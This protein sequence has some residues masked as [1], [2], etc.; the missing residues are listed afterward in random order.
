MWVGWLCRGCNALCA[1]RL[2]EGWEKAQKVVSDSSGFLFA[3]PKRIL[4]FP[5]LVSGP[6]GP[7][8]YL[9]FIRP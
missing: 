6:W 2:A 5:G 9:S 7:T 4:L 3:K 8:P 1:C